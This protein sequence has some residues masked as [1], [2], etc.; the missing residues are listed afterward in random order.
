MPGGDGFTYLGYAASGRIAIVSA[1]GGGERGV[2]RA[3][4][5]T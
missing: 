5:S 4:V 3:H 2:A 1:G